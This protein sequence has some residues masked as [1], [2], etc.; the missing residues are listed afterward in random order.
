M[1]L[2]RKKSGGKASRSRKEA[3]KPESQ[4]EASGASGADVSGGEDQGPA[5][6]GANKGGRGGGWKGGQDKKS[7]RP[8]AEGMTAK[9]HQEYLAAQAGFAQQAEKERR[10]AATAQKQKRR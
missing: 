10:E 4:S 8:S 2:S 7:A 1:A 9:E 6:T 3:K 5:A